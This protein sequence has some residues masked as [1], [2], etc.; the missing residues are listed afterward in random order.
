MIDAIISSFR[1]E[2][3]YATIRGCLCTSVCVRVCVHRC[4]CS[5]LTDCPINKP[6]LWAS[7]ASVKATGPQL[8]ARFLYLALLISKTLPISP[9]HS[10]NR[11]SANYVGTSHK[12]I[13]RDILETGTY[14]QARLRM[15]VVRM[16]KCA[17]ILCSFSCCL[18]HS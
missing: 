10:L 14:V 18:R 13:Q 6:P 11:S 1:Q 8:T 7:A 5:T 16:R 9:P 12:Y 15:M 2:C 17:S 4:I 3:G